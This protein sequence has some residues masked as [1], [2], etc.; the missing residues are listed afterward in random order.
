MIKERKTLGVVMTCYNRRDKTLTCLENVY[1]QEGLGEIFDLEVFMTD[2][3][4]TDGT[5]DAVRN[6]FP[7]VHV[8]EGNGSLFWNGGMNLAY[9]EAL[10]HNLDFYLWLNDDTFL[11]ADAI[12]RLLETDTW[13]TV[14]GHPTSMVLGGT[15]DPRTGEFSYGG[16]K[17]VSLWTLKMLPVAPGDEPRECTT[18]TGNCVLIPRSVAE[19]VGNI[20]PYYTH[21]WGDPDYGLRARKKGCTVWLAAGYIG[22]C[23]SNPTAERWT[24][25]TLPLKERLRDFHSVKGYIKKDWFFY[26]RRHGGLLWLLLWIKP[27]VDM[28]VTS[29]TFRISGGK[30]A[31]H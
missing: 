9:G 7:E 19:K 4:S 12:R 24:D 5:A 20:E 26:V 31:V 25:R 30:P 23:E 11:Y 27:Y 15:A 28:L 10:K 8:L 2:D 29:F 16:F 21:R 1:A 22:T 18:N 17:R 6:R 14:Q 3:G 13:L